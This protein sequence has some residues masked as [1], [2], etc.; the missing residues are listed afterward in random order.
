L[1]FPSHPPQLDDSC[2][3]SQRVQVMKLLIIQFSPT[4]YF[5]IRHQIS[6]RYRTTGKMLYSLIFT[7]DKKAGGLGL[8]DSKHYQN[9]VS[10]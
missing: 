8:N 10:S 7:T 9:S 5:N 3:T 4:S 2:Y 6:Q 1:F